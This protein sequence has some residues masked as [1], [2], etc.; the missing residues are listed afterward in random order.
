MSATFPLFGALTTTT[1]TAMLHR[2][3]E[4]RVWMCDIDAAAGVCRFQ[5][6]HADFSTELPLDPMP[7]PSEWRPRP[8]R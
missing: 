8:A 3:L 6:R 4:E 7:A 5:A 1:H 2:P